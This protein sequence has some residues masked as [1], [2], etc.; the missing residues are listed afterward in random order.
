[1]TPLLT[2]PMRSLSIDSAPLHQ[3]MRQEGV[4]N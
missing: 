1:M 2:H 3:G 4:Y